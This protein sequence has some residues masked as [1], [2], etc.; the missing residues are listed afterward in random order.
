M[1]GELAILSIASHSRSRFPHQALSIQILRETCNEEMFSG[2]LHAYI[3]HLME[4][5]TKDISHF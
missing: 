3:P 4:N 1:A 2:L 5:G